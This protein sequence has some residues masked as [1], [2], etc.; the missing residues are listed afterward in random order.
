LKKNSFLKASL[1]DQSE[2]AIVS[3]YFTINAYQE[4]KSRL[5]QLSKLHFLFGEPTF[6]KSIGSDHKQS[7]NA[8]F[9]NSD[10]GR[11]VIFGNTALKI[12]SLKETVNKVSYISCTQMITGCYSR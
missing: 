8:Q 7:R 1:N 11:K 12:T 6:I 5:N 3:A 4:L 10:C 9:L 2:V